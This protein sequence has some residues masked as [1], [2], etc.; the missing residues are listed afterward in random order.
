MINVS[1]HSMAFALSQL[2][3]KSMAKDQ[4]F[5]PGNTLEFF[6]IV[7]FQSMLKCFL[8]LIF[9]QTPEKARKSR[10]QFRANF[11]FAKGKGMKLL[12]KARAAG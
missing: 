7:K 11:I 9:F 10:R 5:I 8:G 12:E 4:D 1:F 6:R 2:T 3:F